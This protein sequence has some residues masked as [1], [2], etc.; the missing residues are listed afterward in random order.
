MGE[1]RLWLQKWAIWVDQNMPEFC[2][3]GARNWPGG[4]VSGGPIKKKPPP[5]IG[6]GFEVSFFG[7]RERL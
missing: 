4:T 3:K 1:K 2:C 7:F 5:K 6:S